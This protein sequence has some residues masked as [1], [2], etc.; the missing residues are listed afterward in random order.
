MGPKSRAVLYTEKFERCL[1]AERKLEFLPNIS[2][3]GNSISQAEHEA[4]VA[5]FEQQL[6]ESRAES[7]RQIE[8]V[9]QQ[10]LQI[11]RA[12]EDERKDRKEERVELLR[13]LDE[14]RKAHENERAESRRHF[15]EMMQKQQESQSQLLKFVSDALS[16]IVLM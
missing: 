10:M 4:E 15:M 14:S 3:M 2:I 11:Q 12:S 7:R 8:S 5:R 6:A 1:F 9:Q 16:L 13:Q